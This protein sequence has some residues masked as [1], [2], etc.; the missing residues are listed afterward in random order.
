MDGTTTRAARVG[1][2][3][4]AALFL[5]TLAGPAGAGEVVEYVHLDAIGNVRAVTNQA[6]VVVERHDYL[7]FGEECTTGPCASNPGLN[8][9]LP[10]KFTAKE[11]DAETGFDYFGARYYGSKI[12][13][14]STVD[15]VLDQSEAMLNPQLWNRYAY[16]RNNPLRYVDPDGRATLPANS[17]QA[18]MLA[19]PAPLAPG[20]S[21]WQQALYTVAVVGWAL[22]PGG[23]MPAPSIT[24]VPQAAA[25]M[26][27]VGTAAARAAEIHAA[28]GGAVTQSKTTAAVVRATTAEG[29]EHVLVASS[30]RVLRPAQR[31]LLKAG[32]TAVGGVGHAEATGVRAAQAAGLRGTEVAASRPICASCAQVIREAS[33][34]IGSAVKGMEP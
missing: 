30:E 17:L 18:Q 10:R 3:L 24:A 23:I 26:A 34:K 28:V 33:A 20:T 4:L 15:P 1:G 32:E 21:A 31:A 19:P 29:A 9:G 12:G 7:P 8:A 5:T 6:Q 16:G 11:R 27:E 2:Q 14:F 22:N 13:R 25:A